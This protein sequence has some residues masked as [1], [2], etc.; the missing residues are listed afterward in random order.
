MSE[1]KLKQA[2]R[3]IEKQIEIAAP[4]EAV[5]RALTDGQELARWFPLEARVKP[6]VGGS[7]FISWGPDCQGEAPI[8]LWK[9][10]RRYAWTEGKPGDPSAPV[11]EWTI[12]SHGGKTLVRVMNS[13]FTSG[14][15]WENERFDSTDYGWGF[16]LVNLRHYL[17]R[18]SGTPRVVAWPRKKVAVTREEAYERI[19]G[20]TGLFHGASATRERPGAA[21]AARTAWNESYSGRVE[22]VVPPRGFCVSVQELN[23]ALLWLT[24]EGVAG[25]HEAQLWL[26]AY[27]VP[28]RQMDEFA[29]HGAALLDRLF[30][31]REVP[32]QQTK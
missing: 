24:I 23:D 18:H 3:T 7:V 4:V 1:A 10:N 11:V 12:E 30:P 2:T 9:P 20:P 27:G 5:W 17:E 28:Q 22:F 19:A 15:D 32:A 16:M 21:Y 6:G 26:S 31:E 25:Q 29:K 8:T 13:G 14:A